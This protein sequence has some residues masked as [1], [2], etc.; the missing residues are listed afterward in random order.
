MKKNIVL[1]VSSTISGVVGFLAGVR[2]VKKQ[3]EKADD[4]RKKMVE[5][6]NLLVE[7][8]MLKQRGKNL[9][10]YFIEK[11]YKSIAIYGMKELGERL[12]D[13]LKETN[14]EVRYAIDKNAD[15]IISDLDVRTLDDPLDKVD[16][17]VVSAIHYFDDIE[18][19][20]ENI[21]DCDIVSLEEV[22]YCADQL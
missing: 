7:W 9:E 16:V 1:I 19:E 5:F 6:Y 4:K 20:L 8:L 18:E 22:V 11:N 3:M 2:N 14:I 10:S 17:I 13:E 15:S 21:V 12:Y